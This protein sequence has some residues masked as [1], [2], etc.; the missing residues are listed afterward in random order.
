M[1]RLNVPHDLYTRGHAPVLDDEPCCFCGS[2]PA[3]PLYRLDE[4]YSCRGCAVLLASAV[5]AGIVEVQVSS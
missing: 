1:T 4:G 5:A 3:D 2:E